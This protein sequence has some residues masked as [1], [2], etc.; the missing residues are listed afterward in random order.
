FAGIL[1][2]E[3]SVGQRFFRVLSNTTKRIND[4]FFIPLF[5]SIAGL[6]VER[7]S[8]SIVPI[9]VPLLVSSLIIG[10]GLTYYLSSHII[11]D[12]SRKDVFAITGGRGAVGVI[13][14]TIAYQASLISVEFYS[15]AILAT[16][17]ISIVM[18][19]LLGLKNNE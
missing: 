15:I 14:A 5:F 8:I 17:I 9:I 10:A 16:V 1:V 19:P 11:K 13:I 3:A 18:T 7:L 4:S 2:H 12:M 6:S